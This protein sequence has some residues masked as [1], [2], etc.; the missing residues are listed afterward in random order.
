MQHFA[1]LS[2]LVVFGCNASGY[3]YGGGMSMGGYGGGMSMGGG[4][5]GGVIPAAIQSHHRV[6]YYDV[7]STGYA[8]P[9]T[10][11]VG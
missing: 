10:V 7:P 9:V 8:Q 11:E 5:G 3:G 4:Y 6:S 2:A 1:L